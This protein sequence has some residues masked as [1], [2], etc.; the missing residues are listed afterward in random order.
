MKKF[1]IYALMLAASAT[2]FLSS[3]GPDS[4]GG[5]EVKP[6]PAVNLKTTSGY[7]FASA[8]VAGD[9]IIKAG[10][11]INHSSKIKNVKFQ[12]TVAG[13]TFTVKDSSMNDKDVNMD[14]IRQ[15]ISTPG[16][17][18]WSIVATDENGKTGTASFTLTVAAADQDL[19][20]YEGNS[21][22]TI[23]LYRKQSTEPKSAL[24]LDLLTIGSAATTVADEFKDIFDN[25]ANSSGTYAPVWASKTGAKFVKVTGTLDYATTT[26]YSAIV[27]Y[28]N[29][30]TPTSTTETLAKDNMYVVQGGAK[31]R[32]YLILVS[33]ITDGSGEDADY[34]TLKVKTIDITK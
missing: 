27:N 20:P 28:F 16:T 9:S 23:D 21:S 5:D 18:A 1:A 26:K 3:C 30:K 32:Y 22:G 24:D 2:L 31:N 34:V 6:D 17:E 29:S 33:S 12:V 25:T 13:S 4:G 7:T 11:I 8:T 10:I 19:I 14:F 15:V